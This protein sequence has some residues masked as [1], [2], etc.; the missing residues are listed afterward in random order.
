MTI[1]AVSKAVLLSAA[2]LAAGSANATFNK[3]SIGNATLDDVTLG[4]E[5]ADK[6]V[7]SGLNPMNTGSLS[8]SL[9]FWNTGSLFWSTLETVEGKWATDYSSRFDFTF[10]KSA[11]GKTG[12]WSITN[13]SKKYD[14]TLDLTLDIHASNASTAFLFDETRIGAGKTLS[15]TWDIEWLNNGG[16]VPGFSNA[17]LFGR[18]LTLTKA[19][20]PVPE[21]ATL[22]MLAGG[23][24]LVALAARRRKK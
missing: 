7:Y 2:L 1:A 10:G 20:S 24:A 18:D 15:G 6:L 16:Q 22:P 13:V 14:A 3:G 23:L 9:A 11:G 21:S 19:V 17:V 12:T 5:I 8:F 4:G